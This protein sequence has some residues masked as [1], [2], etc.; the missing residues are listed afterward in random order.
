MQF[1]WDE[2]KNILNQKKHDVSFEEAKEVFNLYLN[3]SKKQ[4][5]FKS[6]TSNII[7]I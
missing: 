2:K 6:K 3:S 5:F 4:Y 1:E 7:L